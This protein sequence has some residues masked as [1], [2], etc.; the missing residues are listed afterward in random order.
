MSAERRRLPRVLYL[1]LILLLIALNWIAF[2]FFAHSNYFLW[3]LKNGPII[4]LATGFLA[5]TWTKL[6]ARTG[7]IS[8]HPA[9]YVGACSQILGVFLLSLVPASN[10]APK[11]V[12]EVREIGDNKV[13][14]LLD[15]VLYPP[16]VMIMWLLA[17]IWV[18]TIAPLGYF[19]TLIA[20]VPSRQAL[21]GCLSSN[22]IWE[23]EGQVMIINPEEQQLSDP[24]TEKLSFA[25]DPFAVTQALTSLILFVANLVYNR[26]G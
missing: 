16:I 14:Q 23:D 7:L 5:P 2:R 26:L 18:I 3:Y 6:K 19:V 10:G 9:V 25:Q 4:S 12:K 15:R 8:A 20:G 24:V 11:K 17:T 21:R 1:G 13:T 22:L